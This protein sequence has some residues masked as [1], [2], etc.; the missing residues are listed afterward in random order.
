MLRIS[1]VPLAVSLVLGVARF[2]SAQTPAAAPATTS[3][4][5]VYVQDFQAL[6]QES[7]SSRGGPVSRKRESRTRERAWKNAGSLSGAIADRFRAAGYPSQ[8]IARDAALPGSG[9]LVT[10][11]FFALD[12]KG[13]AIE[14]PSLLASGSPAPNT[15]VTV[16]VADLA[17]DPSSPFIVFG[18][19]EALRGQGPPAGWNPY[20]VAAKFVVGKVESSADIQKFAGEIVDTI[21]KN[22]ATLE[23]RARARAR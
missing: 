6:T 18:T 9:W 16:S 12:A 3:P 19:D 10:G 7:A 2:A 23:E 20:V 22:R 11:T 14:K 1:R 13:G 15:Q 5:T 17:G 21:L 8:R 4:P